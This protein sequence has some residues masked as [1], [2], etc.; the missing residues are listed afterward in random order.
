EFSAAMRNPPTPRCQAR[1]WYVPGTYLVRARARYFS[2]TLVANGQH[3]T[4]R[5][6]DHR[7]D[8]GPERGVARPP[9]AHHD[10]VDARVGRPE[11]LGVRV[12]PRRAQA[13][14]DAIARDRQQQPI[15]V[16]EDVP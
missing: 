10:H 12:A 14:V 8:R 11:D 1:T 3:G 9:H 2:E 7:V 6:A 15:E 13:R 4:A 5:P 16:F